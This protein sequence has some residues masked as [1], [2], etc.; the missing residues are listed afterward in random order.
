MTALQGTRV[1]EIANE[2]IAFAGKLLGDMGA[3]IVLVEPSEHT[4]AAEAG[5]SAHNDLY[6][7]PGLTG[8]TR[9]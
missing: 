2:R 7:R 4:P 5:V 9:V 1:V 8:S 6:L 3:D